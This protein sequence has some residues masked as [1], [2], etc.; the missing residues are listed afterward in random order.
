[1][2]EVRRDDGFEATFVVRAPRAE[3]WKRLADAQPASPAL[4]PPDDGQWWIPGVEGAADELEVVP[5]ERLR[6][7]KAHFPCAGTEIVVTLEDAD[8]GTRIT[9]S[10]FGF[11]PGFEDQRP[12]LE[13]G[14]WAIR[15]DL[16]LWFDRGVVGARHLSPWAGIGCDVTET[17]AGLEASNVQA[18]ACAG[19]AGVADGDLFL[20]IAGSP[21]V[22]VRELSALVRGPLHPGV[23]VELRYLRGG[24][25]LTGRGTIA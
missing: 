3:V 4:T 13:A 1:M 14:W 5:E 19:R 10:Q 6:A 23:D 20:T 18:A 9:F 12:W 2:Y 15:A 25:V 24:K 7:R 22:N 8:T 16:F 21:V 11:G 17:P